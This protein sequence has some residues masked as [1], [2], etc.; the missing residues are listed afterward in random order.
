MRR[1]SPPTPTARSSSATAP[2]PRS[3]RS[4]ARR[5]PPRAAADAARRPRGGLPGRRAGCSGRAGLPTP[6]SLSVVV[7]RSVDHLPT[8]PHAE[9]VT[10]ISSTPPDRCNGPC[11]SVGIDANGMDLVLSV[12]A[13]ALVFPVLIFIGMSTRLAAARRE[14]RFAALRLVGATPRQVS[15]IATVESTVAAVV[16]L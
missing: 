2:S 8:D 6:A 10:S 7:G 1:G 3:C 9:R 14:Q 5:Y 15:V 4:P 13:A 11:Y 12:V 16:G